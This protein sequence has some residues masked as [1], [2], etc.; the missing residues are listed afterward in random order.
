MS[1][2]IPS[3]SKPS[4]YHEVSYIFIKVSLLVLRFAVAVN[5]G[6][7]GYWGEKFDQ[8]ASTLKS[9]K[10]HTKYFAVPKVNGKS[11]SLKFKLKPDCKRSIKSIKFEYFSLYLTNNIRSYLCVCELCISGVEFLKLNYF[12]FLFVVCF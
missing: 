8:F 7:V 12:T 9:I 3:L 4:V 2:T 5:L 10:F 6:L 11:K 1:F